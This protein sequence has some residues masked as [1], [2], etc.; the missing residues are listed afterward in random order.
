MN[1]ADSKTIKDIKQLVEIFK[2]L[3]DPTRLKI[4]MLLTS[5]KKLCVG[6]MANTIG[7]SQPAISQQLKILKH[8]GLIDAQK[9]GIYVHYCINEEMMNKFG[10]NFT[11]LF[12]KIP[13]N[14]CVKCQEKKIR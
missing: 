14:L 5:S 2:A 1:T 12:L 9:I 8:T 6:S 4:L 10:K 7:I 13:V 11:G 3:G